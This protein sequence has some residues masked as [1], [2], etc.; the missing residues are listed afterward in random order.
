M[1]HVSE[2]GRTGLHLVSA[3]GLSGGLC[4]SSLCLRKART[5]ST[6]EGWRVCLR[7]NTAQVSDKIKVNTSVSSCHHHHLTQQWNSPS[8]DR[9]NYYKVSVL[10]YNNSSRTNPN[11]MHHKLEISTETL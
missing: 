5:K 11:I 7:P 10:Q 9:C 6:S 8:L 1:S 4:G 2:E 3:L